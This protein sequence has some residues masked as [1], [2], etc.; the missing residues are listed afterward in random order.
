MKVLHQIMKLFG[1]TKPTPKCCHDCGKIKQGEHW[2]VLCWF[3][4]E[5]D[6]MKIIE[7][8]CDGRHPDCPL[9]DAQEVGE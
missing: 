1:R 3:C 9:P 6:T 7:T 4:D 8:P 2:G 5:G